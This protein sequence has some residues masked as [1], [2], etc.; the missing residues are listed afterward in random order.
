MSLQDCCQINEQTAICSQTTETNATTG[1]Q[2]RGLLLINLFH[3]EVW[4]ENVL[5]TAVLMVSS[6]QP[7]PAL[8]FLIS[9]WNSFGHH[10]LQILQPFLFLQFSLLNLH[11]PLCNVLTP[12]FKLA[13][14]FDSLRSAY[15]IW[16]TKQPCRWGF[17]K[18]IPT[19]SGNF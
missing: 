2:N 12:N 7:P 17:E 3:Q 1:Q 14:C 19:A 13:D 4:S 6:T 16:L 18:H 10:L 9:S 5:Y 8:P 15:C 11:L